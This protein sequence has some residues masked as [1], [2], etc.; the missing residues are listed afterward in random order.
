MFTLE[1][2]LREGRART[3]ISKVSPNLPP[4]SDASITDSP[5]LIA[6]PDKFSD[7]KRRDSGQ[8]ALPGGMRD[9]NGGYTGTS[10][11][12]ILHRSPSLKNNLGRLHLGQFTFKRFPFVRYCQKYFS[13]INS[14]NSQLLP[15]SPLY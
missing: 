8:E 9:S 15:L 13:H 10:L 2:K 4:S 5:T 3:Q 14:F 7:N 1:W 12:Y 11:H 6:R